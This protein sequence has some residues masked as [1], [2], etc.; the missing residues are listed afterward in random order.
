MERGTAMNK[1]NF[2]KRILALAMCACLIIVLSLSY[3]FIINHKEHHCSGKNCSVCEQL[4]IAENIIG[5][6][7][8]ALKAVAVLTSAIL[9]VYYSIKIV[10]IFLKNDTPIKRKVRMNH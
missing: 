10:Y 8:L 4:Q 3:L 5:Q 9:F 6:I 1:T 7:K 2:R